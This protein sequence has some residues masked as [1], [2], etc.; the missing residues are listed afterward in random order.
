MELGALSGLDHVLHQH[1][2]GDG[3]NTAG[4]GGD[5]LDDGLDFLE[6]GVAGHATL[7]LGGDLLGVPV[8]GDVDDDLALADEVLG[9]GVQ[10]TGSGDDDVSLAA[11]G[12]GEVFGASVAR[13]MA[14]EGYTLPA[15]VARG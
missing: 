1:G 13:R 7:A 10:D 4:N 6:H 14:G 11:D 5:G 8:H 9:Q 15:S 3:T 12:G 2:G